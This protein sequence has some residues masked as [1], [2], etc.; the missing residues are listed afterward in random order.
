MSYMLC[1]TQ[2]WGETGTYEGYILWRYGESD[3]PLRFTESEMKDLFD[4]YKRHEKTKKK[5]P[6]ARPEREKT[7]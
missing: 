2:E 3:R 7:P 1:R 4:K 5:Q 6:A